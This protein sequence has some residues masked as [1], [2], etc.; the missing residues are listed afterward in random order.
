MKK[1]KEKPLYSV[2]L[3]EG[4]PVAENFLRA[5]DSP[6]LAVE[7]ADIVREIGYACRVYGPGFG[8]RCI[9]CDADKIPCFAH[10][11]SAVALA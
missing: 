4:E 8:T 7:Y 2:Y 10:H 11:D 6:V 3:S 9:Y 1:E 5:F